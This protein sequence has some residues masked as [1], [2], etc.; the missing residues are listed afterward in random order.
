MAPP[1]AVASNH[2]VAYDTP[3]P[4][5]PPVE[6][7]VDD[8]LGALVSSQGDRIVLESNQVPVLLVGPRRCPLMPRRLSATAVQAIAD[9]LFPEAH[10]DALEEIG[11]TR[12]GWPGF[13]AIATYAG[14]VLTIEITRRKY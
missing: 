8:L 5:A 6:R 14:D 3:A 13:V 7:A 2:A 11:G 1:P 4:A 10:L 9:Y 12:Y